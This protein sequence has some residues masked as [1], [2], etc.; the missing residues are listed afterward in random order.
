MKS[1]GSWRALTVAPLLRLLAG[2]WGAHRPA[3]EGRVGLGVGVGGGRGLKAVK[4]V[5]VGAGWRGGG[6][7]V[8]GEGVVNPAKPPAEPRQ[9]TPEESPRRGCST[10]PSS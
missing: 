5:R 2:S 6:G 1:C 9:A 7:G 10:G 4:A 3:R 8:A